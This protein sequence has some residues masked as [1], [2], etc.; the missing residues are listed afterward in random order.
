M[1]IFMGATKGGTR[2]LHDD[3]LKAEVLAACAQPGASV[4]GV[5]LQMGLNANLVHH[6]I[7]VAKTRSAIALAQEE[8]LAAARGEFVELRLP[9]PVAV[10]APQ[11]DIRIEFN[12]KG[13]AV[14][15][16][17]PVGAAAECAAWM[18]ELLR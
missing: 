9:A 6:W 8:N 14:M 10:P 4:A 2:R 13:T 15:M 18:R 17:W 16:T 5:A 7:R 12:R 11:H 1:D 3:Q